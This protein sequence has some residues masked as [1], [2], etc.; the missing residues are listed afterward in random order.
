MRKVYIHTPRLNNQKVVEMLE[1]KEIFKK[2]VN[3]LKDYILLVTVDAKNYQKAVID[4]VKLL[5]NDQQTP[6]VYVTLNKPYDII[7]RILSKNGVDTRL[8]IFIDVASRT[9]ARKIE[10]CLY[11]GNPEKLSDISVAIEQSIKALTTPEK[12]LI[13][14]SLN[15]LAIYNKPATLAR[16]IHF[17]ASKIREWKIEGIII[18]LEKET[19][20]S[21]L[22]ELTQFSDA[23]I[24]V[25]G[26][27]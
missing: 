14:D 26:E 15:T 1:V 13:F 5:V 3:S 23:R 4:V 10:N 11:I 25:G 24:D 20:Q 8:I 16:F 27:T 17:L 22:D 9:E 2:E 12:F 21:L 7:Q 18:T 6:G 19:E